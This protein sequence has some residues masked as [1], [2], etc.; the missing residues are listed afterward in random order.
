MNCSPCSRGTRLTPIV[1]VHANHPDELDATLRRRY[2]NCADAGIVL[3][4]QAVLLRGVNE[5]SRRKSRCASGW[6]ICA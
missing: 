5:R 2:R 4:N 6:S 3:L 1:V